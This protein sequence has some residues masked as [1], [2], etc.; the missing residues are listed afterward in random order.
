MPG[1]APLA[2]VPLASAG[3]PP[4]RE[5]VLAGV[6]ALGVSVKGRSQAHAVAHRAV[7][8]TGQAQGKISTQVHFA[9]ANDTGALTLVGQSRG[10][11]IAQAQSDTVVSLFG[12]AMTAALTAASSFAGIIVDSD[13]RAEL[14]NTG[15]ITSDYVADG[16]AAGVTGT[17]ASATVAIAVNLD[18][19]VSPSNT[20]HA[21]GAL[22][23]TARQGA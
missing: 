7:V 13:A 18:L 20:A 5:A 6:F 9:A 10:T 8:L 23:F 3:L 16:Q 4:A 12:K 21:A 15:Q 17:I 14:T 22:P 11:V 2:A 1:F 19:A